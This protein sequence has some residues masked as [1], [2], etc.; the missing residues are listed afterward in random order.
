M[1]FALSGRSSTRARVLLPSTPENKRLWRRPM[2][3]RITP[4]LFFFILCSPRQ[5]LAAAAVAMPDRYGAATAEEILRTGGN[6]VDAAIAAAFTLAVTY[7]EAGNIGGGGFMLAFMDGEPAFLDFRERAPGLAE[8]DMYLDEG[9]NFVQRD[10]IYGGRAS[11]VPGTVRGLLAAHERFGSL[12]W[13]R[14]LQPAIALA[15]NGFD[16]HPDLAAAAAE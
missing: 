2:I 15:S 6:A 1:T 12:P 5:G 9:G 4:L 11:G 8:R 14:L 10:A 7:P 16:V 3:R 13:K